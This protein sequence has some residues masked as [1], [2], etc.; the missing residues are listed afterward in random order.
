MEQSLEAMAGS[1]TLDQS[2]LMCLS[3]SS[4]ANL[5]KVGADIWS[6]VGGEVLHA[7]GR[8]FSFGFLI[9]KGENGMTLTWSQMSLP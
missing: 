1:G 6:R 8:Q 9:R 7:Q 4:E 2:V 3:S 5:G